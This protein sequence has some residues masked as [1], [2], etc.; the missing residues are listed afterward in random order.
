MELRCQGTMPQSVAHNIN[1]G[2]LRPV[3]LVERNPELVGGHRGWRRAL[4]LTDT[5]RKDFPMVGPFGSATTKSVVAQPESIAVIKK[6]TSFTCCPQSYKPPNHGADQTAVDEYPSAS[7]LIQMVSSPNHTF[8]PEGLPTP[9]LL[10][11]IY[12]SLHAAKFCNFRASYS[13]Q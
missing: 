9:G 13:R 2:T 10:V 5:S 11:P 12:S 3:I 6:K 8:D 1:V 7:Q 4:R